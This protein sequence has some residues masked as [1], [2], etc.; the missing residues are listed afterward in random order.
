MRKEFVA[1]LLAIVTLA[2]M[3]SIAIFVPSTYMCTPAQEAACRIDCI[4]DQLNLDV[5]TYPFCPDICSTDIEA[6]E[7]CETTCE[8]VMIF[9]ETACENICDVDESG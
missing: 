6:Y 9:C 5:R 2:T 7:I 4:N 8:N 3:P 1:G